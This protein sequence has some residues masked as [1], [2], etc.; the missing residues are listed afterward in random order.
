MLLC[1]YDTP[2]N[3]DI[4]MYVIEWQGITNISEQK[5]VHILF[6]DVPGRYRYVSLAIIHIFF[7]FILFLLFLNVKKKKTFECSPF[8]VEGIFVY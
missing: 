3:D 8:T 6:I 1:K 5:R 4:Q 2:V 7:L